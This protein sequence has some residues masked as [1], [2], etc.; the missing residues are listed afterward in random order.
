MIMNA[1]SSES[2]SCHCIDWEWAENN[3]IVCFFLFLRWSSLFTT[4]IFCLYIFISDYE[5]AQGAG[6]NQ[7]NDEEAPS[8]EL[9][10]MASLELKR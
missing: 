1:I 7:R 5:S 9:G 4:C 6:K 3:F 8:L 2:E 10:D